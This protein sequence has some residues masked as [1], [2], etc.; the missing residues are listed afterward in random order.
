MSAPLRNDQPTLSRKDELVASGAAMSH[1]PWVA[2]GVAGA[3]VT[4]A[5]LVLHAF[6][7]H[8][9]LGSLSSSLS[10][11]AVALFAV[12]G[13]GVLVRKRAGR[14]ARWARE[15][16]WRFALVPGAATAITVFVLSVLLGG[17]GV[18]GG[19][20]TSVWHGAIAYGATGLTGVVT[21]SRRR[22]RRT[23]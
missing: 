4:G 2:A 12:A 19:V 20:F 6:S 9:G 15:N 18:I 22:S 7:L 11:G 17:S 5:D 1:V 8:I 3:V 16:P 10:A 21:G 23:G 13:G 14:A